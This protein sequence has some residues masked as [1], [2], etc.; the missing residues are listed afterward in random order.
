MLMTGGWLKNWM[1]WMTISEA[2]PRPHREH[3]TVLSMDLRA[4]RYS[5]G[6]PRII[7]RMECFA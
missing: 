3:A 5:P 4:A 6:K 2:Q 7:F 1:I